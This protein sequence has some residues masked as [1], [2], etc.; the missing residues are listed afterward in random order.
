MANHASQ[1]LNI[2]V[3]RPTHQANTISLQLDA[4][5]ATVYRFPTLHITALNPPPFD[6]PNQQALFIFTSTNAVIYGLSYLKKFRLIPKQPQFL[7]I[8]EKTKQAL[9]SHGFHVYLTTPP[10]FNSEAL[11]KLAMLSTNKLKHKTVFIIKGE[12]GR[13]L[14]HETLTIRGATVRSLSVYQRRITTPSIQQ[15]IKIQ[16]INIDIIM[17]TSVESAQNLI[18]LLGP[19]KIAWLYKA[20][21]LLGS[22]RIADEV[23]KLGFTNPYWIANNPSDKT[24]LT[25]LTQNLEYINDTT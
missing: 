7:A 16:H 9:I 23:K 14:L 8:G 12:N 22:T 25:T 17:L 21:L 3:T 10:P 6:T 19:K 2:L 24:M 11:L 20:Q 4:L 1:P 15:I 18:T 13:N 5:G